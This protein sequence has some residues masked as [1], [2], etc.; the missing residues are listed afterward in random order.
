MLTFK[1]TK[2]AKYLDVILFGEVIYCCGQYLLSEFLRVT[3]H[4]AFSSFFSS[5]SL[6]EGNCIVGGGR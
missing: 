5:I 4:F 3:I 6:G 2:R 1:D